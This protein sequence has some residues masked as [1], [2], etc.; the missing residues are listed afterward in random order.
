M[1]RIAVIAASLLA[2]NAANSADT[3]IGDAYIDVT[4]VELPS[5]G[6][7]PAHMTVVVHQTVRGCR[8]AAEPIVEQKN[9]V[10]RILPRSTV[11]DSGRC[12]SSA[13]ASRIIQT[14]RLGTLG[15]GTYRLQ[16]LTER[17]KI[18]KVLNI[19]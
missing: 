1:L 14:A 2:L 7:D 17:T 3:K 15:R 9:M 4:K 12:P 11:T 5:Q 8:K 16:I 18:F 13:Q 19:Y 10:I 6:L